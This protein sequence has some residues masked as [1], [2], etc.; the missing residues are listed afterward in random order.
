MMLEVLFWDVNVVLFCLGQLYTRPRNSSIEYM[1]KSS[2]HFYKFFR[3]YTN[4][5]FVCRYGLAWVSQLRCKNKSSH[6]WI[7]Y[8]NGYGN[9][10]K[11]CVTFFFLISFS[12]NDSTSHLRYTRMWWQKSLYHGIVENVV[13]QPFACCQL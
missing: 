2:K 11:S 5:I 8:W 12:D 3:C 6:T 10:E 13:Y 7:N 4:L 1:F 9:M